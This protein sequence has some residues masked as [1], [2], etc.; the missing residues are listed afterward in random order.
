VETNLLNDGVGDTLRKSAGRTRNVEVAA[1]KLDLGKRQ[2]SG[3]TMVQS[4]RLR[5][6]AVIL[7]V[8]LYHE[9]AGTQHEH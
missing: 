9:T 5:A 1:G 8:S 4:I 2:Q 6:L 3:N 7:R